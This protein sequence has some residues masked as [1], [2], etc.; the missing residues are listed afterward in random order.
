VQKMLEI[1][2]AIKAI[3]VAGG[4]ESQYIHYQR[5]NEDAATPYVIVDISNSIDD[6]TLER[7]L[8]DIDGIDNQYDTV[9]LEELMDKAD[10]SLHR[11]TIVVTQGSNELSLTIYRENRMT[12]ENEPE[13]RLFRRRYIYQ[14]RTHEK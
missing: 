6:G 2:K 3:L 12:F 4:I 8:M 13:K 1:R 9:R 10:K 11:K 14:L 5:T 7:F